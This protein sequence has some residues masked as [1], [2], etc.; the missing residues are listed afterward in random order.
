MMNDAADVYRRYTTADALPSPVVL[1]LAPTGHGFLLV[2]T[3]DGLAKYDGRKFIPLELAASALGSG[4]NDS[5]WLATATGLFTYD[6]R[7]LRALP[8]PGL[9]MEP[10]E[11]L[12]Y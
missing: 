3:S 4:P 5:A 7:D 10:V 9:P 6:L 11:G 1:S 8:V 12:G 2:L